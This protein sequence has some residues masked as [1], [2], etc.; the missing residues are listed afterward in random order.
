MRLA[1]VLA[2]VGRPILVETTEWFP[3]LV[4]CVGCV[5]CETIDGM[6]IEHVLL[7]RS[8]LG[9]WLASS[10]S[11]FFTPSSQR[12]SSTTWA[13]LGDPRPQETSGSKPVLV[14]LSIGSRFGVDR[15]RWIGKEIEMD[16]NVE[17]PRMRV[18]NGA[19]ARSARGVGRTRRKSS[20]STPA[21]VRKRTK[22]VL[23]TRGGRV[24]ASEGPGELPTQAD[25]IVKGV[26]A[27][28]EP[29]MAST[30]IDYL[31]VRGP[32]LPSMRRTRAVADSCVVL[33]DR[34]S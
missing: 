13:Q 34:R 22:K 32:F 7:N 1:H 18:A 24:R 28:L 12:T 11:V 17:P 30:D 26:A 10:W 31:Q 33:D 27:T 19:T 25:A 21:D 20:V 29:S 23:E 15:K 3:S 16:H 14:F 2:S 5:P 4:R 8:M 9:G 6:C